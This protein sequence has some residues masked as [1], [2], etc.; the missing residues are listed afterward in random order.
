MSYSQYSP[1]RPRAPWFPGTPWFARFPSARGTPWLTGLRDQLLRVFEPDQHGSKQFF[2][3]F[4]GEAR[5]LG[6]SHR[7]RSPETSLRGFNAAHETRGKAFK[8]LNL[9]YHLYALFVSRA[10]TRLIWNTE[11]ITSWC[12]SHINVCEHMSVYYKYRQKGSSLE[13]K[14][15]SQVQSSI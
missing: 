11:S 12:W 5:G 13:K 9:F 6:F 10:N 3:V 15:Y 1:W 7:E 2:L 8:R 14:T 4:D